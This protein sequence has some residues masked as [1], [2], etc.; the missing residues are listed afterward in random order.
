LHEANIQTQA[1]VVV[2][3]ALTVTMKI[4]LPASHRGL[5]DEGEPDI[6]NNRST[7]KGL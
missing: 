1:K 3:D 6:K 5:K 2:F 7:R 4:A